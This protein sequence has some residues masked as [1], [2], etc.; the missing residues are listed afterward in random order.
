MILYRYL[1][2]GIFFAFIVLI[3]FGSLLTVRARLLMHAVLGLA[4]AF[5]GVAGLFFHLGSPFMAMMQVLIYVGAVCVMLVFGVMVGQAPTQSAQTRGGHNRWLG[6]GTCGAGFVLLSA[7]LAR[8][9]WTAAAEQIGDYSLQHLGMS[10]LH[11][12]VLAFE[13]ISVILLIAILGAI[14]IARHPEEGR[15]S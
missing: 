9:R 3:F 15:Q 5:I 6:L 14:I 1:A 4:V 10:F 2:E 7:T 8:T 13:L 12:F 11:Q